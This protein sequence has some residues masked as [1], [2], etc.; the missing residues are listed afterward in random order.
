MWIIRRGE[1]VATAVAVIIVQADAR[2][3][4]LEDGVV[5][6][7]EVAV[8]ALGVAEVERGHV[9]RGRDGRVGDGGDGLGLAL[10]RRDEPVAGGLELVE[11]VSEG[12]CAVLGAELEIVETV[13]VSLIVSAAAAG[14]NVDGHDALA[15]AA[16]LF[17][18]EGGD[19]GRGTG[20]G[21]G[22]RQVDLSRGC[23]MVG[24]LCR[25]R[26]AALRRSFLRCHDP[27]VAFL[28]NWVA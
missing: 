15:I 6:L 20:E 13:K 7:G 11:D 9:D 2:G 28:Y 19:G 5:E 4:H 18:M 16:I 10:S 23:Q 24:Y 26:E 1:A 8:D 27:R 17:A 14:G 12:N 25:H 22:R 3:R 21:G